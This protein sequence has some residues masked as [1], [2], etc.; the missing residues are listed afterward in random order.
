MFIFLDTETTGTNDNDRL[1]QLAYKTDNG[2]TVNELFNPGM[3]ISIEAM[4]I[5]HITNDMVKNKPLFENSKT[6]NNVNELL[7]SDNSILVAHNALFDVVMIEKEG[8]TVNKHICTLKLSRYLDEEGV[9]PQYNLQYLRYYLNLNVKANAHDA[10][11]DVL[12]L[13]ALFQRLYAKMI[14]K[15][16]NSA[17]DKM[18]DISSKPVLIRRMPF[19]KHKGMKMEEIPADYL[20]WLSTTDL[21]GDLRYTVDYYMGQ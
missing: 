6:W 13:E 7:K 5:H 4:S 19:G 17:S 9:I 11:G 3:P 20:Q 1:C 21:E 10:L 18:I 14:E 2:V 8:I 15:Y 16:Q 12:V